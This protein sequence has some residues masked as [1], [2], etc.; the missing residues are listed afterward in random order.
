[1]LCIRFRKKSKKIHIPFSR[2]SG[3][4]MK[5]SMGYLI[6]LGT[7]LLPQ[8]I[9]AAEVD[10]IE[11]FARAFMEAEKLAWEQEEFDAL[12]A[13]EDPDAVFQNI[14]GTVIRGWEAHKQ[15]IMDTKRSFGGAKIKQEWRYL[16]GEGNI[17]TV[18]YIWTIDL[19]GRP[20]Q[21]R[22]IAVCR[23][24]DGKLVE[25]WGAGSTVPVEGLGAGSTVPV[26]PERSKPKYNLVWVD[27]QGK[28]EEIPV[29]PDDYESPKISPDGTKVALI[30]NAEEGSSDIYILDLNGETAPQRLTFNG[31]ST[32]PLW[33]PDGQRIV[34]LA[35]DVDNRGIYY[36]NAN[37][38][39]K[40]ELLALMSDGGG[41]PWS[42]ADDGKTLVT[43][44]N[45]FSSGGG[46][47]MMMRGGGMRGRGSGPPP[48]RSSD[49]EESSSSE[50]TGGG[51]DIGTLSMEG[52]HEWKSILHIE[53]MVMD[54]QISPDGKWMAYNSFGSGGSG[55]FVRP[56]PDVN[57]GSQWQV[58][59][60][61]AMGCLW[62]PPDG[63][64]LF[65][66]NFEGRSFSLIAIEVET[67]PTFNFGKSNPIFNLSDMGLSDPRGIFQRSIGVDPDGKRFLIVK[68]VR[69]ADN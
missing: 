61:N 22:G 19:P 47:G 60:S 2:I 62:S 6:M 25:E 39:G 63:Q 1:M 12:Q 26:P 32:D 33:A 16:M 8:F 53:G 51:V 18:S 21:L 45:P 35:G 58:P 68:R 28:M 23:L 66:V 29:P 27:R 17:F 57:S 69:T 11:R 48:S 20:L 13:L 3:V 50:G 59:A 5:N 43:T 42:W 40:E 31:N 49:S 36:K 67:E 41:P 65:Y 10:D 37:G 24:K 15:S 64:E 44:K 52:D 55:V 9:N 30:I 38:T 34:F 56:F 14:D 46:M 54:L 7:L 4:H